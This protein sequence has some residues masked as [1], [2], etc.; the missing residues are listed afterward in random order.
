MRNPRKVAGMTILG[1]R[2]LLAGVALPLACSAPDSTPRPDSVPPPADTATMASSPAVDWVD[3]LGQ[4]LVVPADTEGTGMVIFPDAPTVGLLSSSALTLIG[5]NGDS[6]STRAALAVSDSQVCGEAP[7]VRFGEGNP[8]PWSI[9]LLGKHVSP[10]R[11]DSLSGL[12]SRDSLRLSV[13]LAR[14][15]SSIPMDPASR[16][17]ALPFVVIGARQFEDG[18][19]STIATHLVRRLPQESAP[20]EEHTF[21]IAER[22]SSGTTVPEWTLMYH[23]RSEGS[24]E[25]V[26]QYELLSAVRGRQTTLLVIARHRDTQSVYEVLERSPSG[27]WRSR[28]H[29]VLSC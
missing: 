23:Q 18:K 4:V 27:T 6:S 17:K 20:L 15:A 2:L 21:L 22:D 19:R 16:F 10:L 5:T 26:E 24:E 8:G 28:W 3:E 29:R 11:S 7:T 12:P 13:A 1:R 25:S 14:L 9:G